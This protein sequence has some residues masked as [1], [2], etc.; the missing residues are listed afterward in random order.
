VKILVLQLKRIGDLVLTTPVLSALRAWRPES[1]VALAVH[2]STAGLLPVIKDLDSA[3]V[4]GPGRGWSPWQ[5]VL[6]GRFDVLLDLTGTDRSAAA[7]W[8]SRASRRTTFEWVRDKGLRR[9]AYSDFVESSVR[10]RHTVDHYLDLAGTLT[11]DSDPVAQPVLSVPQEREHSARYAVIHPFTARPEKN[12]AAERWAEVVRCCVSQGVECVLTGG[13]A[14]EELE[15]HRQI[16]TGAG[17]D[18]IRSL[19]G[20]TDLL[21]LCGLIAN[22]EVVVSSD[23]AAVHLAAAYERPQIALFGPTNPFHWRPR[24][25]RSVVF[26]AAQP[27]GPLTEFDPRMKGAPMDRIS[28]GPVCRAI[29]ALLK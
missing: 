26:S 18:R 22:A 15:H 5:Q 21:R 7:T 8:L 20:Q 12:W 2:A 25:F 23:T 9:L 13:N 4:F 3:I 6:T 28:T 1:H 10:E 27:E 17:N 29:E 24:H 16:L 19:T 11:E 14:P